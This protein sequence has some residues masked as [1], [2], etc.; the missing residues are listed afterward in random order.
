MTVRFLPP[1]AENPQHSQPE[2]ERLAE[3]VELRQRL[4]PEEEPAQSTPTTPP[5]D[6]AVRLLARKAL[7]MAELANALRKE[8]YDE[9]QIDEVIRECVQRS[10]LDDLA[11]AE[12]VIEKAE[13]RKKLG[14]SAI[15]RE[16]KTR[17]ISDPI[18]ETAL[19]QC[20]DDGE[21]E[22]MR[23]AAEERAKR[24][25]TLDRATAERR[26]SAYLARRGFSGN[27]VFRTVREV[28]DAVASELK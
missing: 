16:L 18:I 14:R 13:Q 1:R 20:T 4:A 27:S 28:L 24:L 7:S 8:H 11:L 15:R 23:A 12:R 6:R 3:V 21:M 9:Q 17:L 22:R 5:L 25:G 2:T 10:Y 19:L 26:L